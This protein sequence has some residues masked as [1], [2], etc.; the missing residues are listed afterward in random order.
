MPYI[1]EASYFLAINA[2]WDLFTGVGI[3]VH[4]YTGRFKAVT[5]P[6]LGLLLHEEDRLIARISHI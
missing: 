5:E 3:L 4:L 6:H 2:V 1:T